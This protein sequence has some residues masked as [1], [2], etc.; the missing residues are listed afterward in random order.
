MINIILH[1]N[2]EIFGIN[3]ISNID[4]GT[5]LL[6]PSEFLFCE[7]RIETESERVG[8]FLLIKHIQLGDDDDD[9]ETTNLQRQR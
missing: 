2:I 6:M 8:Q 5:P 9:D 4:N 3:S 7:P 1:Y